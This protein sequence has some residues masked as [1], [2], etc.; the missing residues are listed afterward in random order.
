M[1]MLIPLMEPQTMPLID[2]QTV[3]ENKQTQIHFD[4]WGYK[5]AMETFGHTYS[6]PKVQSTSQSNQ[7]CKTMTWQLLLRLQTQL[8]AESRG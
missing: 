6:L 1:L 8:A 5:E 2:L 7:N 4:V 3:G